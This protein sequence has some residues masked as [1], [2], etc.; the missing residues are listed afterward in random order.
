M[1]TAKKVNLMANNV[2]PPDIENKIIDSAKKG[3]F[4]CCWYYLTPLSEIQ[5][6]VLKQLGYR[7]T[8]VYEYYEIWW[9]K[10]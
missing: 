9:D 1:I 8:K 6:S 3:N 10:I 2:L 4:M 7:I 5:L